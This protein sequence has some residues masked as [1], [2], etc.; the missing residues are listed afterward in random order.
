MPDKVLHATRLELLPALPA[1]AAGGTT[2]ASRIRVVCSF[3]CSL[4]GASVRVVSAEGGDISSH[5]LVTHRGGGNETDAVALK[6]PPDQLAWTLRLAFDGTEGEVADHAPCD[7]EFA[8]EVG[9][10]AEATIAV[11]GLPPVIV[12][13]RPFRFFAG[14][15]SSVGASLA[16]APLV[17]HDGAGKPI[18]TT[19]L[20]GDVLP[21]EPG[22]HVAEIEAL[23]PE[24]PHRVAWSVTLDGAAL[25]PPHGSTSFHFG[26]ATCAEPDTPVRVRI[27]DDAT[28]TPVAGAEVR[29]RLR[30]ADAPMVFSG[31]T[32]D[33]GLA[34][35]SARKGTYD[36]QVWRADYR[37]VPQS[38]VVDGPIEAEVRAKYTPRTKEEKVWM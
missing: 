2:L 26:F 33:S 16:G 6:I 27:V 21:T 8:V 14:A 10:D 32:G 29:L 34:V 38:V 3:G 12:A 7:A 4:K 15:K 36:L 24:Q 37:A 9:G 19:V 1:K 22:L 23:A 25:D 28:L 13:G 18:V 20:P 35:I 5:P 17:L 30:D 31:R 11:W